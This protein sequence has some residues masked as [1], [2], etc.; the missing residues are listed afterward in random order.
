MV[1]EEGAKRWANVKVL[2]AWMSEVF[3]THHCKMSLVFRRDDVVQ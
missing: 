3:G 2:R 1:I